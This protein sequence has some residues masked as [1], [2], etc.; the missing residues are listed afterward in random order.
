MIQIQQDFIISSEDL[1]WNA[2]QNT[3]I[4]RPETTLRSSRQYS[5]DPTTEQQVRSQLGLTLVPIPVTQADLKEIPDSPGLY[6]VTLK[7]WAAD[8]FFTNPSSDNP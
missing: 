4:I 2:A 6:V 1:E 5:L 8:Q 7:G 3:L